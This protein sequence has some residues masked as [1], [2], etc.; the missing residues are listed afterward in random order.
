MWCSLTCPLKYEPTEVF[1][2][3]VDQS[4]VEK[5]T[6]EWLDSIESHLTYLKWYCGHYHTEKQVKK[7]EFLFETAKEFGV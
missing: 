5:A 4:S 6:E 3:F 1:L 7:L 2:P